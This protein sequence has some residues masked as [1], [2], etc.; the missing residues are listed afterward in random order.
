MP[1]S[2]E[3]LTARKTRIEDIIDGEYN[4]QEGFD[5]NYVLT[6]QGLVVSRARVLGT[7]VDTF[8][9]DDESYGAVT[10][11]DGSGTIRGKF[12]QDLGM[13]EDVEE[14]DIVELIGKVKEYEGERYVN[15]E[16][17][18][19]RSP[20]Y[21]LVRALELEQLEEEWV[22]Y[23]ELAEELK[24]DGKPDESIVQELQGKGL[25]EE[26]AEGVLQF[27][28]DG[29]GE[30]SREIEAESDEVSTEETEDD[31]DENDDLRESVMAAIE[32]LDEG[33]GVEYSAIREE[34]GID[35]DTLED[36]IND[37]LSD[38]TCYEPRPGRIKKL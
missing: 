38:G 32:T 30:R 19:D 15:P 8:I 4:E 18:L 28:E 33:E 17:I 26:D 36:V 13:M 29:I 14:G 1:E 25:S 31:E 3:R 12:F 16:L 24:E 37:L 27:V 11:D 10:V 22:E 6:P 35:E 21:E 20:T 5:P 23:V 2:R 7:V 9:N 34:A